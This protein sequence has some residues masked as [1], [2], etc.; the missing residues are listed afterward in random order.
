MLLSI[1]LWH[2]DA[3]TCKE[4]IFFASSLESSTFSQPGVLPF[5]VKRELPQWAREML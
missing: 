5:V 4:P 2:R 1:S 3:C